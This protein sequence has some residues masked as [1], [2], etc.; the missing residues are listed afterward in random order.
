MRQSISAVAILLAVA[1]GGSG[2]SSQTADEANREYEQGEFARAADLFQRACDQRDAKSC[3]QLGAMYLDGQGVGKNNGK[4]V[5]LLDLGCALE[6][7]VGCEALGHALVIGA[8]GKKDETRATAAFHKACKAGL[9][10]A[11]TEHGI[12]LWRGRGVAKDVAQAHEILK[13]NCKRDVGAACFYLGVLLKMGDEGVERDPAGAA[14][15]LSKAC[16]LK[17][18]EAC[19]YYDK[20]EA[21][22]KSGG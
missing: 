20:H 2:K 21:S 18:R 14:K 12:S 8:G 17:H 5:S 22:L 1:C 7:P 15:A 3:T 6:D 4:G 11:C 9:R 16:E 10:T 19:A 13:E